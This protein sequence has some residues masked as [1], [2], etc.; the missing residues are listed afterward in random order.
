MNYYILVYRTVDNYI[1]KRAQ[2]R[3]EHLA[4]A[5]EFSESKGLILAGALTDP[6]DEALLIFKAESDEVVK[7]FVH[8]DPYVN[9]GLIKEWYIR[10][11]N[12]VIGNE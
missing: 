5:T 2:Y 1:E 11:W 4:L 7:S 8:H 10:K 12:V 3:D 9:N 6:P